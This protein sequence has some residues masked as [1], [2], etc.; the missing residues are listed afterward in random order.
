[1][2]DI[3]EKDPISNGTRL[4]LTSDGVPHNLFPSAPNGIT[5]QRDIDLQ[6]LQGLLKD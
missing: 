4:G 6:I 5:L 3:N 2:G 1:M